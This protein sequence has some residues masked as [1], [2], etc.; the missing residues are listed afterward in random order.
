VFLQ[1][2]AFRIEIEPKQSKCVPK[3][4]V[5]YIDQRKI[6]HDI[7]GNWYDVPNFEIDHGMPTFAL[8]GEVGLTGGPTVLGVAA[9]GLD[10]GLGLA[11]YDDRPAV[12]R[13]FGKVRLVEIP[14]ARADLELHT[15][16]YTRLNAKFNWG[17]DGLASLKGF[18]L[19]EMLAPK[20]N[21]IAY[22]DACLDFV[23]WC[24]GARAIVSSKGVAVCLKI[25][26]LV[27]D[28]EPG[29]GYR[30][31]DTFPD[32]Y[33]A[34]CDI[35]EYKEHI[36]SGID[37]HIRT[38]SAAPLPKAAGHHEDI[39]LP[40]GLPGATVVARGA[41]APPKVTLIGPRGERITS[42]DDARP[43]QQAPFFV[44]KDPRANLTQF[45]ISKPSAGRWRVVVE[46]GSAP[47]VSIA[48]ANGLEKPQV[49]GKV[50]G[51][52]ARRILSYRVKPAAGQKVT[53]IERGPSAGR[54]IG[55]ATGERGRIAFRPAPG[56]AERRRIV[57]LVTQDG[58]PRGEYE[59]ARYR[60]PGIQRPSRPRALRVTRR[61]TSLRVS[62]KPARPADAHEVRVRLADGRRL[63]YRTR[64][65]SLV[66][67]RAGRRLGA[68][69]SVRGVLAAGLTGSAAKARARR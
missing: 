34:G 39:E 19:F 50:S 13:A 14:L 48:S 53:F 2:I 30:W 12:F 36:S 38:V 20:F 46:Q 67:R 21:A 10:A 24:A 40:P 58:R 37:E 3:V 45:A 42:P 7:T 11:T 15:N 57:A 31:G 16:G 60:A 63:L 35:G 56:K 66:V 1:R 28:W 69:V 22:V 59:V 26:V 18:L 6:L 54:R 8:C 68:A 5:E 27:D 51:R 4:G 23:D 32:L 29:F 52:G 44:M 43:V 62:W 25:D 47:V 49:D 61:G 55:E 65:D 41:G 33:F 64:R 17:I 9:I